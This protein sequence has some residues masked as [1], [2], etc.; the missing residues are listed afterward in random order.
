MDAACRELSEEMS[1]SSS[2]LIQLAVKKGKYRT[3]YHYSAKV[4]DGLCRHTAVKPG[5]LDIKNQK[6]VMFLIGTQEEMISHFHGVTMSQGTEN[7]G[8]FL[9]IRLD[10]ALAMAEQTTK[11]KK[12]WIWKQ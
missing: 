11:E 8:Y 12:E 7:I 4:S 9:A 3:V 6:C 2:Q 1:F 5:Y 10:V